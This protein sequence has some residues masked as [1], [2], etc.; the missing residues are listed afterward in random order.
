MPAYFE[1]VHPIHPFLDRQQIESIALGPGLEHK[2]ASDKA[3]SVLFYAILALGSQY[4]DGGS[5]HPANNVA[6]RFFFTALALFPDLLITKA[7]LTV[8]QAITAMAIFAS[9]VSCMQFE[10]AMVS[11]GVKKAI[12]LGYN[13]LSASG[14]DPRNRTF[15]VLFC[16]EKT[17]TFTMVKSSSIMDSDIS[18]ALPKRGDGGEGVGQDGFDSFLAC[19]RLARLFSRI[20]AAL[21]SASVRDRSVNYFKTTIDHLK[22]ELEQWRTT[23]AA[24]FQPAMPIKS[25]EIQTP[26]MMSTHTLLPT[27]LTHRYQL[28]HKP[29]KTP[30]QMK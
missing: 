27:C 12:M 7:S 23:I 20:Y 3:W 11:E 22:E 21:H 1:N 16:L 8:V 26:Q 15:W 5:F 13:Q 25:Y 30:Q 10:Y 14:D 29:K 4:H 24:P 17:M 2:L 28:F 9:N 18:S 6:W 19:I